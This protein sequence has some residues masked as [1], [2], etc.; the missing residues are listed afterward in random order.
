[1]SEPNTA[2][3]LTATS[4]SVGSALMGL[5][6][7]AAIGALAG[8]TIFIASAS[9]LN[10]I[11]RVI[12]LLVSVVVGYLLAPEIVEHTMI[13]SLSVAAFFGGLLSVNG[14]QMLLKQLNNTDLSWLLRGKK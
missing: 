2:V 11:L 10:A 14:A 1:M 12:Y 13:S 5:D 9:D 3:V 8:A 4:I 6:T 7:E